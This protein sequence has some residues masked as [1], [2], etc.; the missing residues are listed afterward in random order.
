MRL[1]DVMSKNIEKIS[2]GEPAADAW[3]RM[4]QKAIR[5]LV[6]MEGN[7]LAGVIS[8]RDL[9]GKRGETLRRGKLVRE[10]M[11]ASAIQAKPET[12]VRQA[13]NLLR[14]YAIGCLPVVDKGKLVGIVTISDMLDL[15]GRGQEKPLSRGPRAMLSRWHA[16]ERRAPRQA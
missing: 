12:T 4:Q 1:Q 13:A 2:G 7:D 6:V 14:G 11:S 3:E 8:E 9:G 16:R 10:L 15:L 5:H